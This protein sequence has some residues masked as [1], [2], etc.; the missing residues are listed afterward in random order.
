MRR[1][2]T[3]R[4]LTGIAIVTSLFFVA[5]AMGLVSDISGESWDYGD[6][7]MAVTVAVTPIIALAGLYL[8]R[9]SPVLG[10]IIVVVGAIPMGAIYFWF[11]PFWALGLAV[12]IIGALRARRF[13]RLGLA[14]A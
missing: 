8:S 12:A 4:N 5:N 13:A 6:A 9:R 7:A 10:G 1:L 14:A 3:Q 2:V 11:P